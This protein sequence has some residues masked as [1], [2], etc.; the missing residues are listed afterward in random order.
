MFFSL[1]RRN[2]VFTGI[3]SLILILG[4]MAGGSMMISASPALCA[5][6]VFGPSGLIYIPSPDTI[7]KQRFEVALHSETYD[8]RDINGQPS[9]ETRMNLA[10]NYGITDNME[11]GFEKSF[12][13]NELYGDPDIA[14]T[15]K[16]VFEPS[17]MGTFTVGGLLNTTTNAYNSLYMLYGKSSA[18]FGFGT[19]FGGAANRRNNFARYGG[20]SFSDLRPDSFFILGGLSFNLGRTKAMLEYD[21]DTINAGMRYPINEQFALDL[22]YVGDHDMDKMY[23]MSGPWRTAYQRNNIN[24][25]V[26]ASF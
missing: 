2:F 21:G 16:Y 25:G 13:T 12:D 17:K 7:E 8:A 19:N 22:A 6:S 3:K 20:Y 26:A 10:G 9:G 24:V 4:M 1:Y 23:S 5:P 14:I 18:Y 15:G 11:I